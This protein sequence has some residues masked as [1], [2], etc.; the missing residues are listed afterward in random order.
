MHMRETLV[1][2]GRLHKNLRFI[3]E[4]FSPPSTS[5]PKDPPSKHHVPLATVKHYLKV[6]KGID[7][8]KRANPAVHHL[9]HAMCP[10]PKGFL[11][12]KELLMA[13]SVPS[14]HNIV[15]RALLGVLTFN[16]FA[17]FAENMAEMFANASTVPVKPATNLSNIQSEVRAMT[18]R[19]GQMALAICTV[20]GQRYA[21][22][23][24]TASFPIMETCKPLLYAIALS[25]C[26]EKAVHE[27]V[28]SEPCAFPSDTFELRKPTSHG[29]GDDGDDDSDADSN[30][31]PGRR[32]SVRG[33]DGA[34]PAFFR[35]ESQG[36]RPS[37]RRSPG[38][39][40]DSDSDADDSHRPSRVPSAA[41]SRSL[42]APVAPLGL[43]ALGAGAGGAGFSIPKLKAF[44]DTDEKSDATDRPAG[45]EPRGETDHAM[46]YN[47]FMDSGAMV[48]CSVIG[49]GH[50]KK[51]FRSFHDAGS[52][53]THVLKALTLMAGGTKPGF[54]NPVFLALKQR[55]L[56]TL[57]V[58]HFMKGME[59]YPSRTQPTDMAHLYFQSMSTDVTVSHLAVIASTLANGGVCPLTG[60]Q[61]LE[62]TV[63]KNVL[64]MLY[65]CGMSTYTGMWAFHVGIPATTGST[66]AT[67]IVI[68]NVMGMVLYQPDIN[69]TGVSPRTEA[70]CKAIT[71]RYCVNMWDQLVNQSGDIAKA[72]VDN[73]DDDD[74]GHKVS[75]LLFFNMCS[76][77]QAGNLSGVLQCLR[78]GAVVTRA[79]YDMRTALHIAACENH[80]DICKALVQAGAN[81]HAEDRWHTSPMEEA[82]KLGHSV[83]VEY[84]KEV[85]PS[86]TTKSFKPPKAPGGAGA[87]AGSASASVTSTATDV[88]SPTAASVSSVGFLNLARSGSGK[89]KRSGSK[90]GVSWS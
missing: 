36:H 86:P 38:S 51:R 27:W 32:G 5:A 29:G 1:L 52:R 76:A 14:G 2:L 75:T 39:D 28:A 16:E 15:I 89:L 59:C 81:I 6:A 24:A 49:R 87:G 78:D 9:L 21:C 11:S 72:T 84:F 43:G 22:G 31:S 42:S 37:D 55:G 56:K 40:S 30:V 54:N 44:S 13:P 47:P 62:P 41:S 85:A 61:C 58:S 7:S 63:V 23:D 53:F 69:D 65:S 64:S 68:P 71:K 8:T 66:G 10:D 83:I 48:V 60:K 77:A 4:N 20:D 18:G 12:V 34:V 82:V 80:L 46:P 25:D 79:D 50:T 88:T 57:A 67:M 74:H 33:A 19:P 26:G 73:E 90:D 3:R 45:I 35:A 70:F 17:S